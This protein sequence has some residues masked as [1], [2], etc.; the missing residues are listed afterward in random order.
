MMLSK[1]KFFNFLRMFALIVLVLT[2]TISFQ[3]IPVRV[4]AFKNQDSLLTSSVNSKT[5]LSSSYPLPYNGLI[6]NYM[7]TATI[8]SYSLGQILTYLTINFPDNSSIPAV[9]NSKYNYTMKLNFRIFIATYS[10]NFTFYVNKASRQMVLDPNKTQSVLLANYISL[11][12][13]DS[14]S[15]LNYVPFW[16]VPYNLSVGSQYPIYSFNFTIDSIFTANFYHSLGIRKAFSA[17]VNNFIVNSASQANLTNNLTTIYDYQTGILLDGYISSQ[18]NWYN[19][20]VQKYEL[21]FWL[22][23]TNA[24]S[25]FPN[26]QNTTTSLNLLQLPPTNYA[27][28]FIGI[29]IPIIAAII[30]FLRIRRIDGGI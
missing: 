28:L 3:I 4:F 20:T 13:N 17:R 14:S 19:N 15:A 8:S 25:M 11:I 21:S 12:Y 30:N 27:I 24:F 7:L 23:S 22:N 1:R 5:N 16:V 10:E 26:L 2:L 9:Y 6:M 18:I 29:G